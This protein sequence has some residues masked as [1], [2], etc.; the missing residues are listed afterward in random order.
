MF[1]MAASK[2]VTAGAAADQVLEQMRYGDPGVE[3][4]SLQ[5]SERRSGDSKVDY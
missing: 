4:H 5:G 3:H 1:V 2:S